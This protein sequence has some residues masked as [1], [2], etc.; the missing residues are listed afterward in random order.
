MQ[1]QTDST[2]NAYTKTHRQSEEC[3][4]LLVNGLKDYAIV[5]LDPTG[6][7]VTW[8]TGA[9]HIKGY[10][11]EEIIG[12]H[13]SLFYPAEDVA[14]GKPERELEMPRLKAGSRTTAGGS[15]KTALGFGP[16]SSSPPSATTRVSSW[17]SP[18]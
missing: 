11:S 2:S 17:A 7:V 8:N 10:L 12:K 6:H 15:V 16:T 4:R 9:E 18:R 14:G 5:M 3:Y 13:F 1:T